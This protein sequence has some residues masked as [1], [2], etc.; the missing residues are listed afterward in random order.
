MA[1][2]AACYS[3][4]TKGPHHPVDT[5]YV[6]TCRVT[7]PSS[8]VVVVAAAP[9]HCRDTKN[10]TMLSHDRQLGGQLTTN[11]LMFTPPSQFD[12]P[13]FARKPLIR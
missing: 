10:H 13:E 4:A 7:S 2:T 9:G 12:K 5:T 8:S 1:E 3:I 6:T 11:A